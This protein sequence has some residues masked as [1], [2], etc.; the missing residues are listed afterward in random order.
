MRIFVSKNISTSIASDND[1]DKSQKKKRYLMF[2]CEFYNQ[3]KKIKKYKFFLKKKE[4][5][6]VLHSTC[7][8]TT[9]I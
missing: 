2:H 4:D 1:L 7:K 8:V 6:T 9:N 5:V 3:W